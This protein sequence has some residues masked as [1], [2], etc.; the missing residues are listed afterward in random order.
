MT[1]FADTHSLSLQQTLYAMGRRLLDHDDAIAEIRLSLP[2]R[3]HI[4]VDLSPFG[5]ANDNEVFQVADRPYGLIEGA[6]GR[7]GAPPDPGAWD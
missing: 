1:A 4:P 3:H 2:N 5:L 7:A 6:V